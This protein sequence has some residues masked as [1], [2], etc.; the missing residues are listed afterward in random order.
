MPWM[1]LLRTLRKLSV[2]LRRFPG[3]YPIAD[4][5]RKA[6]FSGGTVEI[7]DFD[8]DIR[9]T[10][11][12][13]EHMGS[14][15]FWFGYYARDVL[16]ALRDRIRPGMVFLDVGANIGEVSLFAAKRVGPRGRVIS[17]EPVNDLADKFAANVAKNGFEHVS[18][19]RSG[20]AEKKGEAVIFDQPSKFQDGSQHRGLGTLYQSD[21]R[22]E[23]K[24]TIPLM[25][26]D[27]V[28]DDT[29]S[30]PVDIMKIDVEGAE[31]P[32]LHGAE[33]VLRRFK[34]SIAIE[35]G[36]DT[37]RQAGYEPKDIFDYLTPFGYRFFRIGGRGKLTSVTAQELG[38]WQDVLCVPAGR[39]ETIVKR[40]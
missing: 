7:D 9:M 17:F 40:Q 4:S 37:C 6:Y 21:L 1:F 16:F 19:L 34:P 26:I 20:V 11:D 30:E 2:F 39:L 29:G 38:V 33:N 27:N 31:L 15:I 25:T 24:Q 13:G 10:V 28:V 18:L 32:A 12:L 8:G 5:L 3:T 35:I 22:N 36:L 23:P 14:Q